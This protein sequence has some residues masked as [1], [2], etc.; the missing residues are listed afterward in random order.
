MAMGPKVA[1][2]PLELLEDDGTKG[3]EQPLYSKFYYPTACATLGFI[4]A[5]VGNWASRRPYFSGIQKHIIAA[6]AG[7][8][9]GK[10]LENYNISHAAERDAV[11]RHYIQLHPED[12][13]P[14]E[15]K[16][17]ADV[18]EPWIPIR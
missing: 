8:G 1:L 3:R 15:R 2:T 7:A 11:M 17:Y 18:I 10:I 4:G 13:P 5:I 16:K 9:I 12:F 6:I 14:F